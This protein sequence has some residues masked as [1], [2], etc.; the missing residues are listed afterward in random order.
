MRKAGVLSITFV[1][2][3]LAIAVNA[4]AQQANKVPR[5]GYLSVLSPSSDST[6][7]EA[8]RL[9]LRDVLARADKVIR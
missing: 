2:V 7:N 4:E 6:R 5:I 3:L 8:F 9:G 1:V